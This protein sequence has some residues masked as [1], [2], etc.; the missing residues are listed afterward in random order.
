M[1]SGLSGPAGVASR[2]REEIADGS[3]DRT[4]P[5]VVMSS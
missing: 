3:F 4:T 1:K 5:V 2:R